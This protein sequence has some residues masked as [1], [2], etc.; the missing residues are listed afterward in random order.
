ML[1]IVTVGWAAKGMWV[2]IDHFGLEFVVVIFRPLPPDELVLHDD[3]ENVL[4]MSSAVEGIVAQ[5][6]YTKP[7]NKPEDADPVVPQKTY[8]SPVV[9]TLM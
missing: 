5:T 9:V 4:G 3:C 6:I 7:C 8:F 2:T 1:I